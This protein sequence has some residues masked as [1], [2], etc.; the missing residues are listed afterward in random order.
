MLLGGCASPSHQLVTKRPER[1]R[2]ELTTDAGRHAR[3]YV[4]IYDHGYGST[5]F[6]VRRGELGKPVLSYETLCYKKLSRA[7]STFLYDAVLQTLREF[8][9]TGEPR[10]DVMDG[11][12]ATIE[13]GIGTRSLSAGFNSLADTAE[14]PASLQKIMKFADSQMAKHPKAKPNDA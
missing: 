5:E 2:A 13:L 6:C 10:L 4:N 9:F 14:L 11:G 8:H 12:Y 3:Y 7:D 1:W